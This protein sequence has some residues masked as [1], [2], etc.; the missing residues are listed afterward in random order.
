MCQL[1]LVSS[2]IWNNGYCLTPLITLLNVVINLDLV[3]WSPFHY[4]QSSAGDKRFS[5]F[6]SITKYKD[7]FFEGKKGVNS[8]SERK[9]ESQIIIHGIYVRLFS[10]HISL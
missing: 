1:L 7:Q 10:S 8:F 3:H 5:F 2:S 9:R 4:L 6:Y